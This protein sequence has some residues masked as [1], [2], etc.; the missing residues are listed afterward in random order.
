MGEDQQGVFE[1]EEFFKGRKKEDQV[2]QICKGKR[3]RRARKN[4]P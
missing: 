1:D 4:G 2:I 3:K